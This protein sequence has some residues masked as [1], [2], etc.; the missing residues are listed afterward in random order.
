M[1]MGLNNF[2]AKEVINNLSSIDLEKIFK[3]LE[4]KKEAKKIAVRLLKREKRR[5][6]H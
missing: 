6:R 3:F 1:K 4:K 5:D 2:S